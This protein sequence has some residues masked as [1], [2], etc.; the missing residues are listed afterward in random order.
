MP[1]EAHTAEQK[2][3]SFLR[4]SMMG[5][6]TDIWLCRLVTSWWSAYGNCSV[7]LFTCNNLENYWHVFN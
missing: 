5:C 3:C 6:V 2:L 4:L 1:N 7:C